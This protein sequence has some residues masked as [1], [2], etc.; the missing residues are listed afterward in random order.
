MSP[1]VGGPPSRLLEQ[2]VFDAEGHPL[3]RVAAVGTRHGRLHRIGIEGPGPAPSPLCFVP[4]ERL[5]VER[6]RIVVAP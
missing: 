3:G 5:T 1:L 4:R 2:Q 6:D